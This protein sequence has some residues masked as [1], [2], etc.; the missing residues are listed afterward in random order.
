MTKEE[1]TST[2]KAIYLQSAAMAGKEVGPNSPETLADIVRKNFDRVKE[3]ERQ[4]AVGL[5]LRLVAAVIE[6][7]IAPDN[8]YHETNV[9]EGHKETCPVYPF[10]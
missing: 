2:A 7:P 6:S 10:D 4:K 5:F 1:A 3:P 9:W 8:K